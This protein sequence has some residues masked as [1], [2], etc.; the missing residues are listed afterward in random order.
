MELIGAAQRL[1]ISLIARQPQQPP[2][3]GRRLF[4]NPILPRTQIC[5]PRRHAYFSPLA[6]IS[7]RTIP[8]GPPAETSI[9][10]EA[11]VATGPGGRA[12]LVS[13]PGSVT[14][15][16]GTQLPLEGVLIVRERR[17]AWGP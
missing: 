13:L 6:K 14:V 12:F 8:D 15:R 7:Q 16:A 10:G 1:G 4:L 17:G 3:V 5:L 9:A 2:D 11:R